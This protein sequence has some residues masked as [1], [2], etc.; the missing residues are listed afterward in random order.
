MYHF[1]R[2]LYRELA[3]LI[4]AER[5][6]LSGEDNGARVLCACEDAVR[7]LATDH[8]SF[9]NPTRALFREIRV[10]FPVGEQH[11]VLRIVDAYMGFAKRHV[12]TL[13]PAGVD[14]L[15]NPLACRATTRK[16]TACRRPPLQ[17]TGYCPSHQHLVESDTVGLAA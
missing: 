5:V 1:S 14:A 16:G 9:A 11:R 4:T 12:A 10:F 7:R 6:C 3:P 13:V 17:P 2:S 15:G 8:T